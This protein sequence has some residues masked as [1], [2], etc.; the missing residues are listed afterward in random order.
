MLPL[1][2]VV[3]SLAYILGLL[4]TAIPGGGAWLL[5]LGMGLALLRR[6]P[7]KSIAQRLRLGPTARVWMLAGLI[8]LL[9]TFYLQA[10]TPQPGVNDIS[11]Q[12]SVGNPQQQVVTVRG[13][14]ET[15]PRRTQGGRGQI[16]FK[17]NRLSTGS[18]SVTL[19]KGVGGRLYVTL[20]PLKASSLH[21]GQ[22]VEIRGTLYRPRSAANPQVFDFQK[23]LQTQGAFAGLRGFETQMIDP[24]PAWGWWAIRQRIAEAQAQYLGE[25]EGPL[26]SAMVLGGRAIDLPWDLKYAFTRVG[27]AH[28]LAASGFQVSLILGVLLALSRRCSAHTQFGLGITALVGFA[29]LSGFEPSILRAIVMGTAGLIGLSI[30][31]PTKPVGLLLGAAVILLVLNPLWIWDLGFQF[32][33]LA[34]LGLIVTAPGMAARLDWLPPA[35]ASLI[36]VPIAAWIWTFPLQLFTFGT[37]A[38]YSVLA[39]LL[40]SPLISVLTMGGFVS[41]LISLVW[42]W[43]GGLLAGLL[44]YPCQVLIGVVGWF[45]QLP[46]SAWAVGTIALWQLLGLYGLL[47]AMWLRQG[48]HRH[49]QVGGL[50][51]LGLIMIPVWQVQTA[52]F[53]ATILADTPVPILVVQE[54]GTTIL[55]NVGDQRT[56]RLTVLPFLRQRGVNQIDWAIATDTWLGTESGWSE[57]M[58]QV[59]VKTFSSLPARINGPG[60][61]QVQGRTFQLLP[62]QSGQTISIGSTQVQ[63]LRTDPLALQLRVGDQDWLLLSGWRTP[64]QSIWLKTRQPMVKPQVLWWHGPGL[65]SEL[66]SLLEPKTLI[67]SAQTIDLEVITSL[68]KQH[69][70][71][72]WTG[73]DGAIRWTPQQRFEGTLSPVNGIEGK[74]F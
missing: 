31:R 60:N 10:R 16:W 29:G 45:G 32:S 36:V 35:I 42:F 61:L 55:L 66:I 28:A 46:G 52:G 47:V 12:I 17:A 13:R 64:E 37:I 59:P 56:A 63:W 4:T 43:A 50:L 38:P 3:L 14:V 74:L 49:W 53:E 5:G 68:Q 33:F 9:A 34:S 57:L 62:W 73:Q 58:E 19:G 71:W 21:P 11:Q 41:G 44:Y 1:N 54:R 18:Q 30:Q 39:N 6:R 48:W 20:P 15:M 70:P 8:G 65:N 40:T 51:A 24:G 26:V 22:T 7:P 72:F 25:P 69:I 23:Y 67:I 2:S 27:L